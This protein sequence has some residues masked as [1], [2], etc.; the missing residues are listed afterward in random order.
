MAYSL[1]E[2][3]GAL[4]ASMT[5]LR[6]LEYYE[7]FYT[8]ILT[9]RHVAFPSLHLRAHCTHTTH[10]ADKRRVVALCSHYRISGLRIARFIISA[11][12]IFFGYMLMGVILFSPYSYRV[13]TPSSVPPPC[14]VSCAPI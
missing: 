7:H 4:G 1:F 5:I 12:P 11:F 14:Y 6:Y 3:M 13:P 9:L 8:L 2:A 10:T